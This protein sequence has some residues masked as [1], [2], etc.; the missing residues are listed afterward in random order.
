MV[1]LFGSLELFDA[2]G[3]QN[4]RA[5]SLLLTGYLEYLLTTMLADHYNAG[6]FS[7]LTPT[8]PNQRGCQLSLDF[9]ERMMDVFDALHA[10]GVIVDERKPTV[11]RFAPV[12][13]YNSFTDVY[14]GVTYLKQ[15]MDQVF[16]NQGAGRNM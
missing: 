16:G 12:P 1:C 3:L 10:R 9:P 4:L 8:D 6:H 2:A 15:A 11:I 5:K 14:K 7:I 13:L